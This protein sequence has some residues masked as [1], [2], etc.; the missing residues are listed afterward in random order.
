MEGKRRGEGRWVKGGGERRGER[1]VKAEGRTGDESRWE[2]TGER[3]G[4]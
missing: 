3:G 1:R 4:E 2:E